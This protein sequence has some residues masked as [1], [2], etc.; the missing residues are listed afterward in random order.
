MRRKLDSFL[1]RTLDRTLQSLGVL[2][3]TQLECDDYAQQL[4]FKLILFHDGKLSG[5]EFVLDENTTNPAQQ[6]DGTK[7]GEQMNIDGK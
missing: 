2:N 3:G 7:E 4:N 5:T 6:Q 1:A